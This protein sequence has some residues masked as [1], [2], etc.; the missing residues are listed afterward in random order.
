MDE[1]NK[2]IE[3]KEKFSNW[4]KYYQNVFKEKEEHKKSLQ[5]MDDTLLELADDQDE[6]QHCFKITTNISSRQV[7]YTGNPGIIIFRGPNAV[8]YPRQLKGVCT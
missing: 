8:G 3:E 1:Y 4:G 2:Y 6:R 5:S 7:Q